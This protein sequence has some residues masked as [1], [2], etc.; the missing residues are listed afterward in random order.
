VASTVGA[1]LD[2]PMERERVA[3]DV[4]LTRFNARK[5]K[6]R[7]RWALVADCPLCEAKGTVGVRVLAGGQSYPEL[8]PQG[9][10][11]AGCRACRA[12][13]FDLAPGWSLP[14]LDAPEDTPNAT[15]LEFDAWAPEADSGDDERE[16]ASEGHTHERR[17]EA[18]GGPSPTPDDAPRSIA[19]AARID[20]TAPVALPS[21]VVAA[22]TERF[23]VNAKPWASPCVKSPTIRTYRPGSLFAFTPECVSR[24]CLPHGFAQR[25]LE[26]NQIVNRWVGAGRPDLAIHTVAPDR[27]QS[28][29]RQLRRAAGDSDAATRTTVTTATA[30]L[31]V[32]DASVAVGGAWE[33]PE[34]VAASDVPERLLALLTD[35]P[36]LHVYP[37]GQA[38]QRADRRGSRAR[39]PIATDDEHKIAWSSTVASLPAEAVQDDIPLVDPDELLGTYRPALE[40]VRSDPWRG[41][42]KDR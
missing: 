28:F 11:V 41:Q 12:H 20:L 22:A 1:E 38:L 24:N 4:L 34:H 36:I 19:G 25:V 10:P 3:R 31:T 27:W 42:G 6:E 8:T 21:G 39:L 18:P 7:G 23:L 2:F 40:E 32:V 37:S 15:V 13:T 33:P 17:A 26:V 9:A 16:H 14:W 35:D 29:S 30:Y 5:V